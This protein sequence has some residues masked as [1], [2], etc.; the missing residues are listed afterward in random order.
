M[1]VLLCRQMLSGE[2]SFFEGAIEV[3]SLRFS[4]GVPDTDTD[5]LAFVAIES[6]TGL[7][8]LVLRLPRP[9][10]TTQETIEE[11]GNA[12]QPAA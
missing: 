7:E 6:E 8:M 2:L 4:I 5:L 10:D 12:R 9:V 3:C 1:L 11:E